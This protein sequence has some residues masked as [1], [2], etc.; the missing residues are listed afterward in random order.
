MC[1]NG[2]LKKILTSLDKIARFSLFIYFSKHTL[3]FQFLDVLLMCVY[4]YHVLLSFFFLWRCFC[5]CYACF[6]CNRV[7]DVCEYVNLSFSFLLMN[8]CLVFFF[9]D[10]LNHFYDVYFC[11]CFCLVF[12]FFVFRLM[13]FRLLFFFFVRHHPF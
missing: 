4:F 8:F 1:L 3:F 10:P 13:S 12:F 9:F 7:S 2:C 11:F 5:L 6:F